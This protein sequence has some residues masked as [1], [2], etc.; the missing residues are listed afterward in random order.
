MSS[1]LVESLEARRRESLLQLRA[2]VLLH[3]LIGR[4]DLNTKTGVL[5]QW[6]ADRARWVV[7]IDG[8]R[9][10]VRVKANNLTGLAES[11][12]AARAEAGAL[13][14]RA[15]VLRA[16]VGTVELIAPAPA[17]EVA[18]PA[19]APSVP[20]VERREAFRL[21][22]KNGNGRL[23]RAEV[24]Q[25]VRRDAAVRSLLGLPATIR[26]EDGTR[27]VFEKVFQAMDSDD[28]KEVPPCALHTPAPT[29]THHPAAATSVRCARCNQ[30]LPRVRLTLSTQHLGHRSTSTSSSAS[31]VPRCP[32]PPPP[33]PRP[34][35]S[36]STPP[37]RCLHQ[38]CNRQRQQR[39]CC[40][41]RPRICRRRHPHP[42]QTCTRQRLSRRHRTC[43]RQRQTA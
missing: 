33:S 38:T 32:P 10:L 27:D 40:R 7:E 2:R 8:S 25:A 4:P 11:A 3:G 41:R 28:S 1:S 9:E 5:V 31:S 26:Q 34:P 24:I 42:Q 22:D 12:L 13:R 19:P 35:L 36:C 18:P 16:E 39:M 29:A 23:S 21:I 20:T 43:T 37:P 15:A 17:A 6:L 30:P 14:A